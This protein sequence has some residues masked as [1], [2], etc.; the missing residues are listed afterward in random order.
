MPTY[1]HPVK[2]QPSRAR[3]RPLGLWKFAA[4]VAFAIVT[5]EAIAIGTT[6]IPSNYGW[7]LGMDYRFF[8]DVGARWLADGSFYLPHQLSGPYVGQLMV[9][10]FYP[11]SALLLFVPFAFLPP[12]LWWALP[13]LILGYALVRLH[14]APWAWL[15]VAILLAWPRSIGIYLFGNTDMW[16]VAAVASGIVWGWPAAFLAMKPV[17]LPF[18][19][20]AVRRR[21]FWVGLAGLAV[22]SLFML[23]LW[24]DYVTAM[25]GLTIDLSAPVGSFPLMMIPIVAWLGRRRTVST[26]RP[27][28]VLAPSPAA[29]AA[30]RDRLQEADAG[31]STPVA[32][33]HP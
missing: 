24:F 4:L 26:E 11:P 22:I 27:G 9:D 30:T 17:L 3:R 14:P 2:T 19:F 33:D 32:A 25:A 15:V 31:G 5:V 16:A 23:P 12:V 10:V 1:D 21:A 13:I 8:R 6:V 20:P 28:S 7:S 18:A 29:D